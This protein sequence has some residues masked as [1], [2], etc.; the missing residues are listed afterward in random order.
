MNPEATADTIVT[1]EFKR[2]WLR[3]GDLGYVDEDG[4]V[5]I[6]GRLKRIF[7]TKSNDDIVYKLF[8][9]RIEEVL[10]S[11]EEV[12]QCGVIV[13]EDPKRLNI[14]IAFVTLNSKDNVDMIDRIMNH[15]K[16]ELPYHMVPEVLRILDSMP[17][18][19]SGKIDYLALQ[20]IYNTTLN[21]K[22]LENTK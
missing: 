20:R 17:T 14:A 11:I 3:T 2:R 16:K 19:P 22:S 15:A 6:K 7:I 10:M 13:H 1:D 12:S 9:Q 5:F 4:F 21:E 18:T 8:P